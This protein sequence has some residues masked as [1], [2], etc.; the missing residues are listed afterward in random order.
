VIQAFGEFVVGSNYVVGAVVFIILVVIQFM[1]VTKGA[2]RIAE[3]AARFTLDAMPGKQMSIDADLNAGIIDE[4]E[5]KARRAQL[6]HEAEFYGAMD[7][8][9]KF[10]KGDAMAGI[11][12]TL[13]NVIGGLAIGVFQ[14]H[15]PAGRALQTYT[16]LTIGDGLVSQIPALIISIAAGVLVTR[17]A[18]S[19]RLGRHI[20]RQV[21]QRPQPFF[22]CGTM[23]CVLG[24]LPGLP[25]LPLGMFGAAALAIGA[26]VRRRAD[27]DEDTQPHAG[28]GGPDATGAENRQKRLGESTNRQEEQPNRV[29]PMCLE[30]GFGLIS[31]VDQHNDG[32]LVERVG[33]IRE[34][35]QDELGFTI[36]P[37]SIQDN[38][39]LGNNEYR[40]LVRRL[41]CARGTVQAGAFLAINPGDVTGG[42]EGVRTK[43]P[44]FG[45]DAVWIN[46]RRVEAAEAKGYTVVECASVITTHVTEV[47]TAHAADLLSRQTVSRLMETAR[48]TDPAVVEELTAKQVS[49]GV[50]HRVLQYLLNE[51][52][53]IH[54]FPL[55]LETVADYADQTKDPLTLC[56]F[57]RQALR[58]HIVSRSTSEDGILHALILAPQ[59]EEELR[60][61]LG[62]GGAGLTGLDPR[63]VE[64]LANRVAELSEDL[65]N[66]RGAVP[67]MVVGPGIRPHLSRLLDR[68]V[69][70]M[71]VLS[72]AEVADDVDLQLADTVNIQPQIL[73]DVAV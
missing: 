29:N 69:P 39:E 52:V 49:V 27:A 3:V 36:P 35:I 31:L 58:G 72:F 40:I 11:A 47:V 4:N 63:R 57:C 41:E 70:D 56:E 45:L 51:R 50:V 64:Q 44:A 38:L 10:V 24:L 71:P 59:L 67:A 9:S 15:M 60:N 19:D 21:L 33:M 7:G 48:T 5:A 8:A 26:G 14:H 37:I 43:D 34:Q 2:G 42:I 73:E 54:D 25:L 18:D 22:L 12:I 55:I 16:V 23:L 62:P 66:R 32:N 65:Q 53:P 20:S 13:I 30:I 68:R 6:S 61:A 46:P 1:V 28:E 17:A